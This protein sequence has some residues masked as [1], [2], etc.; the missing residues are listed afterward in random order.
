MRSGAWAGLWRRSGSEAAARGS[1]GKSAGEG[2]NKARK[3]RGSDQDSL[4]FFPRV[5]AGQS[6]A[7]DLTC[8]GRQ[9][10]VLSSSARAFWLG[11]VVHER[12]M[13]CSVVAAP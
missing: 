12:T 1:R 6:P 2:G 9:D 3:I 11:T 4:E 7:D 5:A 13:R 10:V 8:Y